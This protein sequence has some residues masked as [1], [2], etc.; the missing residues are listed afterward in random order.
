MDY[1]EGSRAVHGFT[2]NTPGKTRKEGSSVCFPKLDFRIQV[3][4]EMYRMNNL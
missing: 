1:T 4:G 2:G 3:R